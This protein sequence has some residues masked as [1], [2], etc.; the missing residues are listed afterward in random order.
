MVQS[1]AREHGSHR[2]QQ[3]YNMCELAREW[4][5]L[6]LCLDREIELY[7]R[8]AE[9][10]PEMSYLAQ[11]ALTEAV[12]DGINESV[13]RYDELQRAEAASHVQDLELVLS[14]ANELER[15]RG[16]ALRE[17]SHD[18]RGSLAVVQ[19]AAGLIDQVDEEEPRAQL[20]EMVQRGVLSVH[21]MLNDMTDLA[22]LE[23]GPELLTVKPFDAAVELRELCAVAQPL[24]QQNNLVLQADGPSSLA[25]EGDA[26]KVRRIAQNLL[27]NALKYTQQGSVEVAWNISDKDYWMLRIQDSGP[28]L[29]SGASTATVGQAEPSQERRTV[30]RKGEGIGLS[31][32]RRL[33]ELLEARLEIDTKAGIGTTFCITFP[34]SYKRFQVK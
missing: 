3:G 25:V 7:R 20:L 33:C 19:G 28:G 32:V 26:M 21:Q 30:S 9:F 27:L 4:R 11:R 1:E 24:A 2:W 10:G 8:H 29:G 5:H 14:E 31:I 16:E 17:A 34:Q 18:L 6:H 13:T 12:H 22:R 15:A 23:A